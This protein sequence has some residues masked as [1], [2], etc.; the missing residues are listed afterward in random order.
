MGCRAGDT[1]PFCLPRIFILA[2]KTRTASSLHLL[3]EYRP[4]VGLIPLLRLV[5]PYGLRGS[6]DLPLLG[7]LTDLRQHIRLA[8]QGLA[9]LVFN[10]EISAASVR[11]EGLPRL[12]VDGVDG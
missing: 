3:R 4:A 12:E 2:E 8:L 10:Y 1:N 6:H 11:R 5:A 7:R 9:L